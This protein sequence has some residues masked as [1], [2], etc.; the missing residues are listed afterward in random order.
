[1][2]KVR[3]EVWALSNDATDKTLEWY[4]AGVKAMRARP[5][6]DHR[7]WRFQAAIHEYVRARDPLAAATD[8]LPSS[9][10]RD[11][12]WTQCQHGS[13]FFL[14]WHR[15]Y[16]HHFEAILRQDIIAAGGPADWALPYWNYARSDDK[17]QARSVPPAF[18][19]PFLP[20]GTANPL[21]VAERSAA[22]NAGTPIADDLD[23]SAAAAFQ[24]RLF[25]D[26][27]FVG[28]FGGP[29][30][31]FM[32]GGDVVGNIEDRPHG[33]MHVAIGGGFPAGWM[34]RFYTAALDPLFWLH[35][36]NIDRLWEVWLGQGQGRAN[37]SVALWRDTQFHFRDVAGADVVMTPAQVEDTTSARLDYEYDDLGNAIPAHAGG[38]SPTP[39]AA[40]T[41]RN[42]RLVG[43]TEQP[44]EIGAA[45][46]RAVVP[47]HTARAV[48]AKHAGV[49][50]LRT[51][52]V[53]LQFEHLTSVEGAPPYDVYVGVPEGE[54]ARNHPD[55]HVGRLSMFGVVEASSEEGPHA[56]SGL[57]Y[58]IEITELLT[59]LRSLPDWDADNLPI[60]LLPLQA[61]AQARV[62]VGR[63]GLY[64]E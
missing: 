37:P 49:A 36:A 30:T 10:D 14:P 53:F 24:E 40:M 51:P 52:R 31:G 22:A 17:P 54:D 55:R 8:A 18:R 64:S 1:M 28:A 4:A 42:A 43:A 25:S 57:T 33:S 5:I 29:E 41:T 15:M 50:P 9:S 2:T 26:G 63:V 44:F 6:N 19:A 62:R 11:R 35:H 16:L 59:R 56:G 34:S 38:I 61:A 20:D 13:W 32:H 58:S 27:T 21:F 39:A 60:T 12:Y 48:T 3:R 46:H 23:V 47:T 7:S 45:A